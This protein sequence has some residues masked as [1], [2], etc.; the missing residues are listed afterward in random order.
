[1][2]PFDDTQLAYLNADRRLGRLATVGKDGMPHVTPVGWRLAGDGQYVEIGGRNFANTKKF[3]DV[4][5][6]AKAALVI[7]EVLPP[8]H[9]RGVE[10]RGRAEAIPGPQPVIRIWPERVI[11]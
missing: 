11:S 9:P 4:R 10:I 7:D 1:M 5:H 2:K 6:S 8:W 3:R